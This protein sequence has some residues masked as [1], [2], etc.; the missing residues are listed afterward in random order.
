LKKI[1]EKRKPVIKHHFQMGLKEIEPQS[2]IRK[3]TEESSSDSQ[4]NKKK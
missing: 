2:K 4:P 3:R 1:E